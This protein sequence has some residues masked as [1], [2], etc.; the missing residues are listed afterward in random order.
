[1]VTIVWHKLIPLP[2]SPS[3]TD[4][5]PLTRGITWFLT[6]IPTYLCAI[7]SSFKNPHIKHDHRTH[8]RSLGRSLTFHLH[9][10]H[11][12]S[13]ITLGK[14]PPSKHNQLK[15]FLEPMG[16]T[17]TFHQLIPSYFT[18]LFSLSHRWHLSAQARRAP[19]LHTSPSHS[20]LG[21]LI[22]L[23]PTTSCCQHYTSFKARVNIFLCK[24]LNCCTFSCFPTL[25]N[26]VHFFKKTC[27]NKYIGNTHTT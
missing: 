15:N 8:H 23:P 6:L 4:A 1:M 20:G 14:T 17:A 2:S 7:N 9:C 12:A 18:H 21:P 19:S 3:L 16:S 10:E 11:P 24:D 26:A 13:E 22:S 25:W 5:S 27:W